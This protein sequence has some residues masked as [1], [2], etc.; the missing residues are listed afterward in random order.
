MKGEIAMPLSELMKILLDYILGKS[1]NS[2][3]GVNTLEDLPAHYIDKI[4]RLIV[5][6]EKKQASEF[7]GGSFKVNYVDDRS[8]Y[9]SLELYFEKAGQEDPNLTS[10]QSKNFDLRSLNREAQDELRRLRTIEFEID[11]PTSEQRSRL[12]QNT[13]FN[14]SFNSS[15]GGRSI[16]EIADN[17]ISEIN[18]KILDTESRQ[19]IRF[20]R[21]TLFIDFGDERN[22]SISYDLN[23]VKDGEREPIRMTS[24][25][26][27]L[28]FMDL[29]R[30]AQ[31]ELRRNRT[32]KFVIDPPSR[33]SSRRI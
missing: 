22:F 25:I 7:V 30:E 20:D 23:Y 19:G 18:R 29:N 31:D 15:A 2:I 14:S 32:I 1:F 13:N 26:P 4:N 12:S 8:Y 9:C 5:E 16:N 6:E 28:N 11:P 21:G 10:A 17:Y 3:R 33:V 27:N 24:R